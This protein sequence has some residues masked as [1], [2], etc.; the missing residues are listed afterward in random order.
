MIS[1]MIRSTISPSNLVMVAIPRDK[2]ANASLDGCLGREACVTHQIADVGE[3]F[4]HV[5]GLHRQQD[6][7]RLAIQLL[8]Q[9]PDHMQKLFRVVI[10]DIIDTR[11]WRAYASAVS[12]QAIHQAQYYTGHV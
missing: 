3:G 6:F 4:H 11:R 1:G 8:L 2:T 7:H 5:S 10:A 9:K 12:G